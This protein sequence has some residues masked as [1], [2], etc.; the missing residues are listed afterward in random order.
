MPQVAGFIAAAIAN[1]GNDEKLL[2]IKGE[3]NRLMKR[4][5]LYA[6]RLQ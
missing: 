6:S 4:F 3:V 2:Q 1:L 5:P